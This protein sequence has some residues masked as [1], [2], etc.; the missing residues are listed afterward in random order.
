MAKTQIGCGVLKQGGGGGHVK[1][2]GS[3][4]GFRV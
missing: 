3:G 4:I 1:V 2:P